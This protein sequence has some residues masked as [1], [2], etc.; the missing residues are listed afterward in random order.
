LTHQR[1]ARIDPSKRQLAID[2]VMALPHTVRDA[3]LETLTTG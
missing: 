1:D 2:V 3:I